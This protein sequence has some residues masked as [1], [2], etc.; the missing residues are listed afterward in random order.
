[1]YR[2]EVVYNGRTVGPN[3]KD[4]ILLRWKLDDGRYA[5]IYGDLH[6]ET[7]TA[8]RLKALENQKGVS[9]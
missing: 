2:R 9:Q 7:V 3:D 8:E 4:K 5:V 1:M 6:H